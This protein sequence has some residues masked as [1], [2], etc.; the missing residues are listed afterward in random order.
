VALGQLGDV[1]QALD[2]LLDANECTERN[3]LGDLARDDLADRVG[4]GEDAPR[5]LL[6]AFRD[7]ETRSRSRSTSSTS[8]VTSSPTVTTSPGWSMCFQDSSET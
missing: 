5:I 1:D 7:S 6:V 2:A 4:P 3:Q 8:T